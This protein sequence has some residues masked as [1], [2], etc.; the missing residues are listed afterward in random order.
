M[1]GKGTWC[2]PSSGAC[3]VAQ[4]TIDPGG[5]PLGLTVTFQDLTRE[6]E[7]SQMKSDFVA[8]VT[9]QLRTPLAGIRW[10]LELATQEGA[11]AEEMAAYLRDAGESVLRLSA[12]VHHLLEASRLESGPLTIDPQRVPCWA[13]PTKC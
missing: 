7:V 8:F 4:P 1:A 3:W 6:R 5:V 2:C 9:H 11:S 13:L 12:L 10:M